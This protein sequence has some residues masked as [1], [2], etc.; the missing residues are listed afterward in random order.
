[1]SA[2]SPVG[3]ISE[4]VLN[5]K[6]YSV[7]PKDRA[8]I[9]ADYTGDIGVAMLFNANVGIYKLYNNLNAITDPVANSS[10]VVVAWDSPSK[11]SATVI[12]NKN[13]TYVISYTANNGGAKYPDDFTIAY[14]QDANRNNLTQ[15]K[16]KLF[17]NPGYYTTIDWLGENK[18]KIYVRTTS[19]FPLVEGERMTLKV[20]P[21]LLR[22]VN[23]TKAQKINPFNDHEFYLNDGGYVIYELPYVH[24]GAEQSIEVNATAT[25][26]VDLSPVIAKYVFSHSVTQAFRLMGGYAPAGVPAISAEILIV[27]ATIIVILAIAYIYIKK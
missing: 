13:G 7:M 20:Q 10:D 22:L 16:T 18:I 9:P 15:I 3:N 24:A 6:V 8:Y 17:T 4:V 21:S 2:S 11:T 5:L 19:P 25:A 1:M 14:I 27:L 12:V 26:P 23:Y